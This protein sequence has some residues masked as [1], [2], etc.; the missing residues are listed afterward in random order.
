MWEMAY[1]DLDNAQLPTH[2]DEVQST[3]PMWRKFVG[4]M[5]LFSANSLAVIDW[6]SKEVPMVDEVAG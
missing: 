5:T 1:Y 3:W 4:N 2:P 6:K